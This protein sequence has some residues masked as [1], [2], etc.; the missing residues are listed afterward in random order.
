MDP[1]ANMAEQRSLAAEITQK[2]D[3]LEDEHA[4]EQLSAQERYD[5]LCDAGRLA[6]LV[7]ALDG[8]ITSGGFLP[9]GWRRD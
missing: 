2:I 7:Q 6:E 9:R 3:E 8:W 1:N 5:F 4:F